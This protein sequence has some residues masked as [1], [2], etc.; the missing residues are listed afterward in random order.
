VN[1]NFSSL[2]LSISAFWRIGF[3]YSHR[4]YAQIAAF[5]HMQLDNFM[6]ESFQK[7][8]LNSRSARMHDSVLTLISRTGPDVSDS[9]SQTSVAESSIKAEVRDR[10]HTEPEMRSLI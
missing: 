8:C 3:V 10:Q 7:Y 1:Q 2:R 4:P 6:Y 5:L 9:D